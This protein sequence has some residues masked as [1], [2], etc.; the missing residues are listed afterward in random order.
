MYV[1][2][3]VPG[4]VEATK[5]DLGWG[6]SL[7]WQPP[8]ACQNPNRQ[9]YPLWAKEGTDG[10][11]PTSPPV[12]R[13]L[14]SHHGLLFLLCDLTVHLNGCILEA[15]DAPIFSHVYHQWFW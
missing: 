5:R 10:E 7:P 12:W 3:E 2:L 8:I 13:C 6:L 11:A 15:G 14:V 4:D 1:H 9:S